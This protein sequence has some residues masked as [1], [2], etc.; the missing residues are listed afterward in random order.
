MKKYGLLALILISAIG[1]FAQPR[2]GLTFA[3]SL[4]TN[5]VK[6]ASDQGDI[7]N[8]GAAIRFKFGLEADFALTDTYAFSTGLI[9]AP[10]RA[11]FTITPNN[12]TEVKEV[13]KSQYLQ[14][15]A[16]VKLYTSEFLPDVTGYFQIGILAEF[17]V[18]SEPLE[19]TYTLVQKFKP[20][21]TS[22][23]FGL[24]AEYDA[25]VSSILYAALVYN[26]GLINAVS[27]TDPSITESLASR[28]DMFG[29]QFGLKF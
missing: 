26:R 4:A 18:F 28:Q 9:Y 10:K 16:T 17:K 5:R 21:D 15:P 1:A 2:L 29:L 8:N 6:F 19:D 12:G 22:F 13:Y 3:P 27:E 14:I 7:T 20:F 23:V 11:G 25:G 24:G